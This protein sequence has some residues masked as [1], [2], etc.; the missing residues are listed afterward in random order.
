MSAPTGTQYE[1]VHA[2]QRAVVTERGA[3]L[4]AY[5]VD[6][7]DLVTTFAEDQYP[8]GCQGLQLMPWPNRIRDGRWF[9]NGVEQ[10]LP[11]NEPER[12]NAIH[13]LVTDRFFTVVAQ[14][15]ASITQRLLLE[16]S[17]GWPG[18]LELLVTHTLG[19]A[20]LG[21]E[22]TATNLGEVTV[23]FGYAAHPYLTA[24]DGAA[25]DDCRVVLPFSQRL[26]SDER[27]LPVELHDVTGSS[28]DRRSPAP[29]AG[30]G[31][32][33]AFTSP[34]TVD[35]IW[36]AVVSGPQTSTVLWAD[37]DMA[38]LQVYT[39]GDRASIAVEPMSCGPNAFNEGPTHADLTV[40][41]TGERT[42]LRWGVAHRVLV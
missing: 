8:D 27:L 38:W 23:P 17:P 42:H 35:G 15:E 21:V 7:V 39:P 12:H 19:D 34:V 40:L 28:L 5:Q 16:P 9:L 4:R 10:L 26:T 13:G 29:L 11:I 33:D 41:A 22:V 2:A 1:L 25:L 32:D 18:T 14:D 31:L 3:G 6:G 24:P 37:Q 36:E 30:L 20:G